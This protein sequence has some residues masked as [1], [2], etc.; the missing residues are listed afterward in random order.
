MRDQHGRGR[1]GPHGSPRESRLAFLAE[2]HLAVLAEHRLSHRERRRLET[3]E[4]ILQAAR[5]VF[6]ETGGVDVSLSEIARRLGFTPA[7][8]YKYFDSKDDL[9]RAVA[10]RAMAGLSEALSRVS[11]ELPPDERAVEIGMAYLDFA[12][13]NPYDIAIVALHE[14]LRDDSRR[15]SCRSRRDRH[16]RLSRRSSPGHLSRLLRRG[17]R[18]HGL[19]RL[20]A[21]TRHGRAALTPAPPSGQAVYGPPASASSCRPSSTG[22]K[23][24]WPVVASESE[25]GRGVGGPDVRR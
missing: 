10:E 9:I 24:T 11:T 21:G 25:A 6:A 1:R 8:L 17:R 3:R 12:R 15:R 20:V 19:R 18:S 22:L 23:D 4:E 13:A 14:S 7:A 16:G 5:E 2:H